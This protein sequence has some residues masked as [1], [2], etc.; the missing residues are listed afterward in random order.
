MAEY[1]IQEET[2]TSMADKIR[3]LNG[4]EDEM[5]P[6]EMDG[7][8]GEA[9]DEV[10]SQTD[11]IAQIA[12]ALEGKAGGSNSGGIPEFSTV[13]IYVKDVLLSDYYYNFGMWE[14]VQLQCIY[15][16]DEYK[17]K[18]EILFDNYDTNTLNKSEVIFAV[19]T[20]STIV[21]NFA[22]MTN[23][24]SDAIVSSV[25]NELHN[26]ENHNL[27]TVQ[28][29]PVAAGGRFLIQAGESVATI[30]IWGDTEI[31]ISEPEN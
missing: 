9:N 2:L 1:L 10:G 18:Y 16:D 11:L 12:S 30:P 15:I 13:R 23:H 3:I 28:R 14:S 19:P 29:I 26:I 27:Q 25:H 24:Y 22:A 17:Q 7:Q 5:T 20:N 4:V 8:L 21:L 31:R 6:A